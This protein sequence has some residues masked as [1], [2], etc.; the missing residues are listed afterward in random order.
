M[1]GKRWGRHCNLC[2]AALAAHGGKPGKR[3]MLVWYLAVGN[4]NS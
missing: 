4:S 2:E 3:D 1:A